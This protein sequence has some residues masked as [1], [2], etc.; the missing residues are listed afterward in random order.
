MANPYFNADYYLQQNPDVFSAG[1]TVATAWDH[2]V[3]FGANEANI[4][5][6]AARAPNPWFDVKYYLANNPDLVRA[7]ITPATALDHFLTYGS[8]AGEDRAP[9]ATIAAAPI[10]EAKLLAYALANA[11]LQKAFGISASATTLTADEQTSLLKHFYS[12]GYN[13]NR[14]DKPAVVVTP[15][16]NEGKTFTLTTGVDNIQGTSGDDTVIA[17]PGSAGGDHTLGAADVINGNAGTDTLKVTTDGAAAM[18][19][20][21]G[22]LSNVE[23]VN[24]QGMTTGAVGTTLNLVNATGVQ[25]IWNERSTDAAGVAVTNVQELA[26]VGV[27]GEVTG[28]GYSVGFKNSLAAGTDDSISIA[29]DGASIA[30]LGVSA[31]N[32][33]EFETLNFAAT[34]SNSVTALRDA[35]AVPAAL[36]ATK[37]V[38]ITGEGKLTLGSAALSNTVTVL[39]ASKNSGGV[40]AT[41]G[42]AGAGVQTVTGGT[43]NDVFY[44]V[45]TLTTADKVD[46][47]E[48]A[49]TIGITTGASLVNGLQVTNFQTLD[50]GGAVNQTAPNDAYD[51]SKLSGITTLKV[52]TALNGNAG[53]T[54]TVNNLAKGAGVE[55][56][57][58]VGVATDTLAINV[59]DAGAGSP[60]DVIDVL[61]KATADVATTG[62]IDINDIETVNITSD[63]STESGNVTHTIADLRVD[64]ALT[65]NVKDGSAALTLTNLDA[66][67]LVLFDATTASKAVS[68]TTN[69]AFAATNGVAFKLGQAA[70]T[71]TL[72]AASTAGGDFFITGGGG[73]DSIALST[74]EVDHVIYTSATDSVAGLTNTGAAKFDLV[75]AFVGGTDKIDLK[76]LSIATGQQGF[77][78]KG[79]TASPTGISA[80]G[81]VATADQLNFFV[82]GGNKVGVAVAAVA[83][84]DPVGAGSTA[85]VFVYVDADGDGSFNAANDLTIALAG[86]T[87][88]VVGVGAN[89]LVAGDFIFA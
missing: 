62:I 51:V 23:I 77:F 74:T 26:T 33:G 45:D 59:K 43:G 25:Q 6:G 12:Y 2:Y 31:M 36:N 20:S 65:V 53:D 54:T 15:D 52:G 11:D 19:L 76:G 27:R 30:A 34:G 81:E 88:G 60:N 3:N 85:G 35:A 68:V 87:V 64:E 55:I 71:L 56:N 67:A 5:G 83:D 79:D 22:S 40:T 39:D 69:D 70:D 48:G 66:K 72:T 29:L 58:A 14:A 61:F 41:L 16:V 32:G 17:G 49:N 4:V 86:V 37:T 28:A 1:Y 21:V 89:N 78:A 75:T 50:I 8:T 44:M 18:S 10:T 57:A 63:K 9:N 7:G 84:V 38:N 80:T 73:G 24:I 42:V 13:E 82:N 47:G 46:G